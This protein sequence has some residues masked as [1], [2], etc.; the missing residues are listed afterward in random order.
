MVILFSA[1]FGVATHAIA[2]D[3]H[4][5]DAI[6]LAFGGIAGGQAGAWLS[7]RVTGVVLVRI[8]ALVLLGA[9]ASLFGQHLWKADH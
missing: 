6:P 9:S 8:V 5:A 4:W 7:K 3:I 2:G 1:P